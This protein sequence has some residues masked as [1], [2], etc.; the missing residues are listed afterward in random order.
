[1][2]LAGAANKASVWQSPLEE[3]EAKPTVIPGT[4]GA[5]Q[6]PLAELAC[7]PAYVCA[8]SETEPVPVSP[9]H[10]LTLSSAV[11]GATGSAS[12]TAAP[13]PPPPSAAG[14][15]LRSSVKLEEKAGRGRGSRAG[16]ALQSVPPHPQAH[17]N[18][19]LRRSG[20]PFTATPFAASTM[21][22]TSPPATPVTVTVEHPP[23]PRGA[24]SLA[25]STPKEVVLADL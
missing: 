22:Y 3:A 9:P 17:M 10:V 7:A 6:K 12:S 14:R 24:S 2:P 25:A 15:V 16:G 20:A 4:P 13:P 5:A 8:S 18:W 1:M 23:T 19:A 21:A 11:L